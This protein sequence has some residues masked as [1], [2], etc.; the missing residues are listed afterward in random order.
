MQRSAERVVRIASTAHP[1]DVTMGGFRR[2]AS[3]ST[4][5]MIVII[6]PPSQNQQRN[7]L[8]RYY[9]LLQSLVPVL[10]SLAVRT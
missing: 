6:F 5:S 10:E 3:L 8:V 9:N 4:M 1:C 7:I 2:H